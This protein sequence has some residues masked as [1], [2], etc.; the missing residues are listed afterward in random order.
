MFR[1]ASFNVEN[2]FSRARALNLDSWSEGK[3]VLEKHARFNTILQKPAYSAADKNQLLDLMVEL[4]IEK[5]DTGPFVIL[6][7][8][9]GRLVTRHN[10]GS[11]SVVA[12]GR[13][14]W[15]GWLELRDGPVND[16]AIVNTG[17]VIRDV[18]ADILAIVEAEDR[19]SLKEFSDQVLANVDGTP[20]RHIMLVDGNDQ[21][22]IDV[23][24]MSRKGF[25]VDHMRSHVDD[26]TPSGQTIFSRD[27][28]EFEVHLPSGET[29][30]VLVNHLKSKGFG[31]FAASNRRRELQAKR[32]RT[33]YD[34]RKESGADFIAVV[35]DFNDTP[36][37]APLKPLMK[38]D[39]KMSS[40]HPNYEDGG[41]PGTF[42]G[43]TKN[44]IIDYIMLS[45]ALFA[46][47]RSGG[48]FRMGAWPGV[49]PKKWDVYDDLI[50]PV[51]AASDHM[52]LWVDIDL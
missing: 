11:I 26:A 16:H 13:D 25:A 32:V 47:M 22:G 18:N 2:L 30:W 45:P 50:K 37:S 3:P 9:R 40:S 15:V 28:P 20:Y 12:D 27:C 39:L 17:R 8:N 19:I 6:R 21:R 52:A 51:Y 49:R 4:G 43:S 7:Q 36:D 5:D 46:Q 14:D 48:I 10:D 42:G 44:N 33:L 29:I 41:F 1:L 35:G 34:E 38:S 31:G 23:G 24:L